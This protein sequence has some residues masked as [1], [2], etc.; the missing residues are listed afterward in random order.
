[1]MKIKLPH[2]RPKD[3]G[4]NVPKSADRRAPSGKDL[5]GNFFLVIVLS[6]AD[7]VLA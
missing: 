4:G 6:L 2:V 3:K 5:K 1:M 7:F